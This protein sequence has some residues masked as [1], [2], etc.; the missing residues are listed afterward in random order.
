MASSSKDM[1]LCHLQPGQVDLATLRKIYQGNVRIELADSARADVL[2]SQ[3][4]VQRI[5]E[6]GRVVY[7]I[8][9]GFGKLAQTMIPAERLAELQR[10][11]VLSHSVGIGEDL[12]D[13]VV[14]LV[15]ATKVLSLSRGHSGI[16]IEVIEALIA[17]F[18]AGVMPCIPEKGS[19]GASGDLAPLAH[20][21]LMLIGEGQVRVNGVKISAVEGLATVGL[22]PFVLG[23]KEGLALLNG[24][25]VSTSL[26]LR[27]LFEGERVFAA[28]LVAGALSLEA[29]KGSVK[30]LDARIHEARGQEGQI[31]VAAAVSRLLAGSDIVTSHANCGRVQDPY[32]I[33]CVPQ[34]MGACLD[35]LKHAARIL[36]I[37]ANAAS[38]N[39]LVFENGDVI[40]GGNFHAEPVAFAADIIAL[41]VAEIGAIS[42]R[43]LA[44][45]LDTGLS[46]LPPFL[47]HDGGVNSGFM[48]AQVTA[49]A[50][51]S[52]NKSL[53]HPGS[54]DSLP[55]SANQEDHVSMATYAARRL[56]DMC[57]N[58]A[59]VVGIEAMAAVQGIDFN[60][61]L[62]SSE[63]IEGE[64]NAVREKVAFLERDRLMAPDVENMRLWASR[65]HWPE[66]IQSLLP[67]FR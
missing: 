24:T 25:Q 38:D 23:P 13:N 5:V 61:P 3:E 8:N 10:N 49:A 44:L 4:T 62:R 15:M 65:E 63:I 36:Q 19:V 42:E 52:E 55:T 22:K 12:P 59:V 34:V 2:A 7:G 50:L 14:R 31:A 54:V 43:R 57:F 56:G 1:T 17:L 11:L 28:G 67:S 41:A 66:P 32:S 60:R 18:N 21:S 26:A 20:L 6:Q 53:A 30:P 37:E 46:G 35:N 64:I 9:T 27:G 40:S 29:I 58:T 48:I 16:R 33:R 39:P 47:V 45:L 51:A